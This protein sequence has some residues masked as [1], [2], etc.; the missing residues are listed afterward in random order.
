[1]VLARTDPVEPDELRSFLGIEVLVRQNGTL[2]AALDQAER[3][4]VERALAVSGGN[5]SD[6]ARV[7]GIGRPSLHRIMKRYGISQEAAS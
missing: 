1:V 4:A 6:A 2:R 5:V 3:E 7:L